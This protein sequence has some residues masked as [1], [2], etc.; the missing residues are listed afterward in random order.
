MTVREWADQW[1]E[2][3]PREGVSTRR[4]YTE[5]AK[6]IVDLIG[7]QPLRDIDRL[8]VRDLL[9]KLPPSV[10]AIVR[11]MWADAVQDGLVSEN[12]WT[13]LRLR[14]SRGR[15]DIEALTPTEIDR[16][17]E[18]AREQ[19]NGYGT[20]LAAVI[21]TLAY[22][23]IRPGELMALR[24]NNINGS[25]QVQ[26]TRVADGT[27]KLPKNGLKRTIVLAPQASRRARHG[28]SQRF[29][30]RVPLPAR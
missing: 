20:E 14:K 28:N 16:L 24:W 22:T 8:A 29:A 13:N 23:G 5:A 7:N 10:V 9:G 15:R 18:I 21:R 2:L 26:R 19:C 27:E 30:L 11:T 17:C 6:R 25:L 4:N 12:P 1:L 3:Y